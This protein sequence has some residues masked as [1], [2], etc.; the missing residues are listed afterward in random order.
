MIGRNIFALACLNAISSANKRIW[1]PYTWMR[2]K[3]DQKLTQ[4]IREFFTVVEKKKKKDEEKEN[5]DDETDAAD[6]ED[7]NS[8]IKP[9]GNNRVRMLDDTLV[10]D[11]VTV[12][13]WMWEPIECD[14][15]QPDMYCDTEEDIEAM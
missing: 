14:P 2:D 8:L 11:Y 10:S 6:K 3:E 4:S 1:S 5:E 13:Y 15:E 9:L 12:N 7:E